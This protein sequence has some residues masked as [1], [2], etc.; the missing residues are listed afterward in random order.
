MKND[1]EQRYAEYLAQQQEDNQT[2]DN[3][4][5]EVRKIR[6]EQLAACD[7]KKHQEMAQMRMAAGY[8]PP[9]LGMV[10]SQ[11]MHNRDCL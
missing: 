6:A 9:L 1:D 3:P 5:E 4:L 11:R 2:E 7:L 10:Q 8:K